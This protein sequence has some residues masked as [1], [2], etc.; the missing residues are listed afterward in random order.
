ML[1][2]R[3]RNASK[4]VLSSACVVATSSGFRCSK[5]WRTGSAPMGKAREKRVAE[6]CEGGMDLDRHTLSYCYHILLSLC[7]LQSIQMQVIADWTCS[8]SRDRWTHAQQ[9]ECL[10]IYPRTQESGKGATCFVTKWHFQQVLQDVAGFTHVLPMFFPCC[11]AHQLGPGPNVAQPAEDRPQELV[12]SS[13]TGFTDPWPI[14]LDETTI[15][16][17]IFCLFGIVSPKKFPSVV[18]RECKLQKLGSI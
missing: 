1:K 6:P 2:Y 11:P 5:V 10:L 16:I 15:F 17:H 9:E 7:E 8:Q 4:T 18:E 14:A 12:I 3:G 13:P